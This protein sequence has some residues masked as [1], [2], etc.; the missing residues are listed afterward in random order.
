MLVVCC[1][2]VEGRRGLLLAGCAGCAGWE[3][4]ATMPPPSVLQHPPPLQNVDFIRRNYGSSLVV[5]SS[6][7]NPIEL[8]VWI[9]TRHTSKPLTLMLPK[10][11]LSAPPLVRTIDFSPT[12]F[13]FAPLPPAALVLTYY[14][15]LPLGSL[16]LFL[17]LGPW[18]PRFLL[19][20]K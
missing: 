4:Y 18:H 11:G 1:A 15:T 5:H 7:R 2:Q 20:P 9:S 3:T 10:V 6:R 19:R 14:T 13:A 8:H 16:F 12:A 17:C